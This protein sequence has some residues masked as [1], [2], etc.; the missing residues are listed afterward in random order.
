MYIQIYHICTYIYGYVYMM[1]D[2]Y[3]YTDHINRCIHIYSHIYTDVSYIY[4]YV[5]INTFTCIW[6]Q[7]YIDLQ[8]CTER[9]SYAQ[10][11]VT[12]WHAQRA[13]CSTAVVCNWTHTRTTAVCAQRAAERHGF[14][15][16]PVHF[17]LKKNEIKE[18]QD[19]KSLP[20]KSNLRLFAVHSFGAS[21]ARYGVAAISRLLNIIGLS[22]KRGL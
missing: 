19:K 8:T 15:K 16:L 14:C 10:T 11:H 13:W 18:G 2:I 4:I 12:H 5:H 7:I 9:D 22:C 21:W 6:W 3:R 20:S 1:T 17:V